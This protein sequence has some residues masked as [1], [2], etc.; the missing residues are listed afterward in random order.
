MSQNLHSVDFEIIKEPWNKYAITDGS[1]L[2]TRFILKKVDTRIMD[3]NK[4]N[5][6]IDGLPLSIIYASAELRGEPSQQRYSTQEL[7]NSISYDDL[8]YDTIHEEWDE[9]M[10]DDGTRIRVKATVMKISRTDKFDRNGDPLYLVDTTAM[11]EIKLPKVYKSSGDYTS[12][13]KTM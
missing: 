12:G 5:Y 7:Q 1:V 4:K 6:K 9:Y 10:L 3:E 2:K 13:T 8:R 11:V